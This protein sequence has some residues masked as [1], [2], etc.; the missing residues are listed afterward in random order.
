MLKKP[1]IGFLT[2][3]TD[4][5]NIGKTFFKTMKE[6]ENLLIERDYYYLVINKN[7]LKD[8]FIVS[9]KNI[10]SNGIKGAHLNP[11]FQAKW[12]N[13]KE[14][15]VRTMEKAKDFLLRK[16]ADTIEHHIEILKNAMPDAYPEY[17]NIKY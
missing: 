1:F 14:Q 16:W 4:V 13:C 9:L 7:N 8:I 10:N 17:F 5:S 6:K 12:D 3:E 11:P 15:E 2:G